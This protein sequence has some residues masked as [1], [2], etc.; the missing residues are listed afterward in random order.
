VAHWA[1][2]MKYWSLSVKLR[3]MSSNKDPDIH[4]KKFWIMFLIGIILNLAVGGVYIWAIWDVSNQ[5][6]VYVDISQVPMM[7]TCL[8]LFDSLRRFR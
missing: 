6:T 8:M 4:N 2:A 3:L 1:F 5:H 7:C